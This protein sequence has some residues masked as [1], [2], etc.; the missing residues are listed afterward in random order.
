MRA[1]HQTQQVAERIGCHRGCADDL[2]QAIVDRVQVRF[3]Y[4]GRDRVRTTRTVAPLGLV[5]KD[6][7][8]YLIALSG[9]EQKTYRLDRIRDL[10]L[11]A[12]PA[13]RPEDFDLATAWE[14]VV[15][16][17]EA[18]RSSVTAVVVIPRA[19]LW[20]LRRQFGRHLEVVD[21]EDHGV[22]VSV[23]AH[24]A[25]SLAEQLAG[26]G[27]SI[28]IVSPRDVRRELARIGSELVAAYG[29]SSDV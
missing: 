4:G 18:R 9:S 6:R 16:E 12:H 17:V 7:V 5:V 2:Q 15:H 3:A 8:W 23:A 26:W 25:T 11:T 19:L 14:Q 20:V 10:E 22:R 1:V 13:V 28:E 24:S 21:D 29:A 27:S